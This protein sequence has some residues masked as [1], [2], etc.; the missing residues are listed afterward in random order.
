MLIFEIADPQG[1]KL[2]ALTQ[3]LAGRS[4]DESAKK[5][6]SQQA[7]IDLAR[8][9]GVNVTPETLGELISHEPLQNVLEPLE[10]NSGVI[11]FKGNTDNDTNMNPDQ[12][13][14]VVNQNAKSAMRRGMKTN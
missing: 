4:K 1:E 2:L 7:F 13:A 14:A 6:I 12:A 8:S 10:P 3:F 5:E 9:L 11:R